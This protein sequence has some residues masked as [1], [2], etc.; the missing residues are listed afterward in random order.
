MTSRKDILKGCKKVVLKIGSNIISSV[1]EGLDY[2]RIEEIAREI[3]NLKGTG[4]EVIIVS[5]GAVVSGIKK[6]GLK[7]RPASIPIKQAAAAVG[8][9]RL[10]W[11][12]ESAFEQ[13]N[14][15]VAQVL[16]TGDD[17]TSRTRLLN[18]RN[19]IST[20]LEYNVIPV[21]NENDTVATEEIRLGDN[22]NLAGF[23]ANLTDANL[24]IILSDVDGLFTEDPKSNHQARL[25]PLV[26]RVTPDI[27]RMAGDTAS[28]E[29]TGGMR[30]KIQ[31]AKRVSASGA[32]T[33]II[34]GLDPKNLSRLFAG[35]E[36]G[37]IFLPLMQPLK[38]RKHWITY[39]L[40]PKGRLVLDDGAVDALR[41]KGKSLLPSGVVSV[42][43]R[44]AVGDPVSCYD[45]QGVEVA[46]GLVNYPSSDLLRIKGLKT[47][48]IEK[49][50][51]Y[52]DYDEVIHRDNL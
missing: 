30:T 9:S 42:S 23:V 21:I 28:K 45:S 52:K 19:T 26:S 46:K 47:R 1:E 39:A 8:Q 48:E 10:M 37:T 31:A 14:E 49:V 5:S 6:L 2:L 17:M 51:G 15:T 41:T 13:F 34:C 22:D 35:E 16:L 32:Y 4:R 3:S 12:W 18:S 50:L 44:F 11:A 38:A 43:G 7:S 24:L 40:R 36:I 33:I 29:G 20:L 27:E 25:I